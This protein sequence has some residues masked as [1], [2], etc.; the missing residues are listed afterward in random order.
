MGEVSRRGGEDEPEGTR[1]IVRV[2]VVT[3]VSGTISH[4]SSN[5]PFSKVSMRIFSVV[6]LDLIVS[7]GRVFLF[8]TGSAHAHVPSLFSLSPPVTAPRAI[9]LEAVS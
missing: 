7:F 4:A 9:C 1:V 8:P 5:V 6:L 3:P 2:A